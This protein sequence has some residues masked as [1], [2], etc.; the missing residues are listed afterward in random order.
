MVVDRWLGLNNCIGGVKYVKWQQCTDL[1]GPT[2]PPKKILPIAR[3]IMKKQVFCVA[4]LW[5]AAGMASSV[6]AADK[7]RFPEKKQIERW[8]AMLPEKPR[9]LGP[10]IEDRKA[11]DAAASQP[12]FQECVKSANHLLKEPMPELTDDLYLEY[13]RTG[14]RT[15]CQQVQNQRFGR[16]AKLVLAECVENRGRFL[17]AIEEAILANCNDKSWMMPAH[18]RGLT[19]FSGKDLYID[20]R[21][22]D[23]AWNLA[24]ADYWLG[25]KTP[26]GNAQADSR[27]IGTP[28]VSA[29]R[30]MACNRL[31]VEKMDC[32]Q[33]RD[34]VDDR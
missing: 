34:V 18:D 25:E 5:C 2:P 27:G 17:P 24:T 11:W 4:A 1:H 31:D 19:T 20:L 10:T 6:L 7:S 21:V 32:E 3:N 13:S 14:N 22:A 8:A 9:G 29:A 26:S 23:V 33:D 28:R 16:I 15:R 12:A 30:T